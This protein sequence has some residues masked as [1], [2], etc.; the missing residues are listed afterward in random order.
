MEIWRPITGVKGLIEVSN[1]GRVRSLLRGT[2]RV[3]KT[4][5]D[6]KGYHRVRVTVE[7]EKMTER[8]EG[9]FAIIQ[10]CVICGRDGCYGS[11]NFQI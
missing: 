1:D 3:L 11:I 6:N 10:T 9:G 4:Q 2:P 8:K 7:R 5:T